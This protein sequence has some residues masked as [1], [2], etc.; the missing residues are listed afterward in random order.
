MAF[1]LSPHR[2]HNDLDQLKR[3][4]RELHTAWLAADPGSLALIAEHYHGAAPIRPLLADAQLVLARARGHSSWASLRQ[5]VQDVVSLRDAADR[6]DEAAVATIISAKPA[7]A[8]EAEFGKLVGRLAER[9]VHHR[10]QFHRIAKTLVDGGARCSIWSAA[11]A[12]L[13][14]TVAQLLDESPDLLEAHDDQGRTAMQRAALVYGF[15]S[16]CADV[17]ELLIARGATVDLHSACAYAMLDRVRTLLATDPT[18]ALRRA[19]GSQPLNWAVRPR[20]KLSANPRQDALAIIATLLDAGADIEDRDLDENSMT[21]LHHVA[22]WGN[23]PAMAELLLSRGANLNAVDESG[24][25]PID[26]AAN[27]RRTEMERYLRSVGAAELPVAFDGRFGESLEAIHNAAAKGELATVRE[28]LG[29]H[30]GIATARRK[31]G[32]TPLH[33]AAHDGHTEVARALIEAGA[34]VNAIAANPYGHGVLHGAAERQLETTR[35]LIEHGADVHLRNIRSDQT[36]LHFNARCG[37]MPAIAELLIAQNADVNAADKL[38]RTPLDYALLRN[39]PRVAEVL[40][41][42]GGQSNVKT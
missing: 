30:P 38:G 39:H 1:S 37:N 13:A 36:P 34:D 16:Q 7:L 11:R 42:H 26:Y 19:Q 23:E 25:M 8:T 15:H 31:S 5:H 17:V 2:F 6:G 41:K 3:Q 20:G 10:A 27:R 9:S 4:A 33:H 40:I 14:E 21:P 24:W 12:G 32:D 18:A 35:L 28:L 29:A 22:E